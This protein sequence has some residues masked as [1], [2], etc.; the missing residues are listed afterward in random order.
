MRFQSSRNACISSDGSSLLSRPGIPPFLHF[1]LRPHL[2]SCLFSSY[3][4]DR[5][6]YLELTGNSGSEIT[7]ANDERYDRME[8]YY[9]SRV[10][11]ASDVKGK[12]SSIWTQE[13]N[14]KR[15]FKLK[16]S[17]LLLNYVRFEFSRCSQSYL[18]HN[19]RDDV[20]PASKG[21]FGNASIGGAM[22]GRCP[23]SIYKA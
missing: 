6:W 4:A 9:M 23:M 21:G 11:V 18:H 13:N 12:A 7:A 16:M 22:L 10:S 14:G 20:W 17:G 1:G 19:W 5:Y 15:Q 3:P 8:R 2:Q